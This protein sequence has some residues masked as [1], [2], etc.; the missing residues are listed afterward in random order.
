MVQQQQE[1]D[2]D[3]KMCDINIHG[4]DKENNEMCCEIDDQNEKDH[5]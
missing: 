4:Q 5:T 2:K 1:D 3:P